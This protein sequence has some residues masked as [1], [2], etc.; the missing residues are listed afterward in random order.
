MA[1]TKKLRSPIVWFGGKGMM[2]A[3]LVPLLPPHKIYVEPFGGG[4]SMLF[5]KQPSDCEV[6]NDLDSGLVNFFRVLRDPGGF[7]QL[8]HLAE[9]T[10]CS[11]EE[12]ETFRR[13]WEQLPETIQRAY[14]WF[15]VARNSFSGHFGSGWGHTITQVASGMSGM[16]SRW[17]STLKM[18]PEIHARCMR[19]QVEHADFRRVFETYDRPETLFYVDPPYVAATR[20]AGQYKHELDDADHRELVEILLNLEGMAVLSGYASGLYDPLEEAGWERRD[21]ETFCFASGRTRRTGILG[22]GAASKTQK[23]TQS[24]WLCPRTQ[25]LLLC[26]NRS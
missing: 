22:P 20:K 7:R 4:A 16:T 1:G 5:A 24:V 15:Y 9:L 6:Y 19:V 10:P 8:L 2:T 13:Q 3:K 23:R 21:F 18:L 26:S 25:E 14:E 17:L 12:F 11:R